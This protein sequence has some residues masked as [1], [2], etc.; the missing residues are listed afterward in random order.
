MFESF[1]GVV[2][3][4]LLFLQEIW[5]ELAVSENRFVSH[6]I[7]L[8]TVLA[9]LHSKLHF[10]VGNSSASFMAKAP[11]RSALSSPRCLHCQMLH[12]FQL[13]I[14]YIAVCVVLCLF[15]FHI[16]VIRSFSK[17][18]SFVV[19]FLSSFVCS[20]FALVFVVLSYFCS[21][22]GLMSDSRF[23]SL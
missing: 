23:F 21:F 8:Q 19:V 9:R 7:F 16:F 17:C 5:T 6:S 4:F 10:I 20:Q 11:Q 2:L 12:P 13:D 3:C 22:A 18:L 1:L 14:L 15:V